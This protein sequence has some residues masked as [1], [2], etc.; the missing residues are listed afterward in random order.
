M[1]HPSRANDT[2]EVFTPR[3]LVRDMLS[4][5]PNDV[6]FDP[7]KTWLEPAAGDGNFLVEIKAR[8][9]QAGHPERHILTNM[10]FG[11][12]LLDDNHYVLQLRL[13][14][15]VEENGFLRPGPALR[16]DLDHFTISKI[17]RLTQDL[18]NF[19]PYA[20]K[21]VI[22]AYDDDG[23]PLQTH[24]LQ[25]DEVYHHRNQI[26][27]SALTYDF[28]FGRSSEAVAVNERLAPLLRGEPFKLV[29][30][31]QDLD[32]AE[33]SAAQSTASGQ[34]YDKDNSREAALA[35]GL[36][37]MVERHLDTL[38]CHY[39][40]V[41]SFDNMAPNGAIIGPK[42]ELKVPSGD[43][44][45]A[46]QNYDDK[47]IFEL[48]HVSRAELKEVILETGAESLLG[49]SLNF[50]LSRVEH[51]SSK[52]QPPLQLG[53]HPLV[54]RDLGPWP[55]T[56]TPEIGDPTV[57]STM[58]AAWH[59]PSQQRKEAEKVSVPPSEPVSKRV[60]IQSS[61]ASRSPG[62]VKGGWQ[63]KAADYGKGLKIRCKQPY[64]GSYWECDHD[65]LVDAINA[66]LKAKSKP[67]IGQPGPSE[68]TYGAS[69]GLREHHLWTRV[70]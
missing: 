30:T 52:A 15:L 54:A 47:L 56:D 24:V 37:R 32:R 19:S 38:G 40:G 12:E 14:Y 67:L 36:M 20:G 28:T 35:R 43:M 25:H 49:L 59:I 29:I 33:E 11:I 34:T 70:S 13:G 17:D 57:V 55:D 63:V 27:A 39:S 68:K 46:G 64:D 65:A 7:T 18:N 5:L 23:D 51:F 60:K 69:S 44:V 16:G 3:S 1:K 31:Q 42:L 8:L 6:W 26:C 2:A 41:I 4:R 66:S 10:L 22:L 48:L 45:G 61:Q 21:T 62:E 58:Q 9:L 50:K 53:M